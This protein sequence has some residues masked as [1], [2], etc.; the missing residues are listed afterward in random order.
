MGPEG[1]G[2]VWEGPR[3]F[4]KFRVDPERSARFQEGP[5]GPEGSRRVSRSERVREGPGGSRRYW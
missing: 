2:R 1:S 5:E 4:L 3:W